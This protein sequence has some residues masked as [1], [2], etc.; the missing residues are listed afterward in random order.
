[1]IPTST[2]KGLAVPKGTGLVA[3]I[4]A[5]HHNGMWEFSIFCPYSRSPTDKYWPDPHE[6]RPSRFLG[7]YNRDAFLPFSTGARACI[8][9]R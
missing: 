4:D 5:I 3:M 8:G 2:S 6:F 1:M 7:D 9:R